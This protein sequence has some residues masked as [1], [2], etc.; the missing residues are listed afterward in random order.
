MTKIE[1][2]LFL[3]S[4]N[5]CRSVFA[6]YYAKW[7]KSTTYKEEL[8]G[9]NFDSAGTRHYYETPHDGTVKYLNSKGISVD[10]FVAKDITDELITYHK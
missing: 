6:E 8:R 5:T 3:C 9:V 10:G 7:L 1:K 2:V 4:G